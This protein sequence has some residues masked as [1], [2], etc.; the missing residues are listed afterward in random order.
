VIVANGPFVPT[1]SVCP[2]KLMM[3]KFGDVMS[4][5]APEYWKVM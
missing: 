3:L 5:V 2:L 1:L 4:G